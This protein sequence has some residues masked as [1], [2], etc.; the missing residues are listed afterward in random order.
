MVTVFSISVWFKIEPV[1]YFSFHIVDPAPVDPARREEVRERL[2]LPPLDNA[3]ALRGDRPGGGAILSAT[4]QEPQTLTISEPDLFP[5]ALPRIELPRL[6]L[7][8][9]GDLRLRN[10]RLGAE[11]RYEELNPRPRPDSWARFGEGLGRLR[12]AVSRLPFFSRTQVGLASPRQSVDLP[13]EGL[14]AHIDWL[15]EPKYRELLF[16]APV[17]GL[18]HFDPADLAEPLVLG[19]KIDAN[20]SVTEVLTPV[21]DETGLLASADAALRQYRFEPAGDSGPREQHG[22]LTIAIAGTEP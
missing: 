14:V 11:A 8:H 6:E 3:L 15:S 7:A 16:A 13:L 1:N 18:L 21:G 9:L 4:V 12:D 20:G 10:K 2:S 22:T 19:F 5:K 17:Q